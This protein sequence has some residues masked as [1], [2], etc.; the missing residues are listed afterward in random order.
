MAFIESSETAK[1]PL[2]TDV[3][4]FFINVESKPLGSIDRKIL[5]QT[6]G[7]NACCISLFI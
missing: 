4:S 7:L 1:M 5:I 2:S 3:T 6:C